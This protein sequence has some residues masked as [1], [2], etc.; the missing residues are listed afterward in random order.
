[1]IEARVAIVH[2]FAHTSCREVE[3]TDAVLAHPTARYTDAWCR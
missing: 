1:M 2:T 3:E